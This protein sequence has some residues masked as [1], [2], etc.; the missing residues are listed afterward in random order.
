[1]ERIVLEIDSDTAK[2]WQNASLEKRKKLSNSL[3]Q[4]ISRTLKEK[5]EDF[6]LFVDR[7]SQKATEKGMTEEKLAQLLNEE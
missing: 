2:K 7:I 6:W 5:D 1:M 4:I 3:A